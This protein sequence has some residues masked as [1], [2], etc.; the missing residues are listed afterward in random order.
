MNSVFKIMIRLHVINYTEKLRDLLFKKLQTTLDNIYGA[1]IRIRFLEA[2]KYWKYPDVTECFFKI[3]STETLAVKD[4]I[5]L[6]G[7]EWI[8]ESGSSYDIE[9][10]KSL[11]DES[12]IW[13]LHSQGG[14]LLDENVEWAHIYIWHWS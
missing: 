2:Q 6:F 7:V 8:F 12:A 3:Y 13:N 10:K 9:T 14:M 5:K 4:V 1:S 11:K